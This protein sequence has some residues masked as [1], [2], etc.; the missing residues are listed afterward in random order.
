[1][2]WM[3]IIDGEKIPVHYPDRK[4]AELAR[5]DLRKVPD[6]AQCTITLSRVHDFRAS[7]ACVGAGADEILDC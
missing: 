6:Y 3:M 7:E 5:R 1:M 4:E 2:K